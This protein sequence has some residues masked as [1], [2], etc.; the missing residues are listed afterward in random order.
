MRL[1]LLQVLG[2]MAQQAMAVCEVLVIEFH[3]DCPIHCA[4]QAI[5]CM[6]KSHGHPSYMLICPCTMN[7]AKQWSWIPAFTAACP[8]HCAN[9]FC[10]RPIGPLCRPKTGLEAE[11]KECL[12]SMVFVFCASQSQDQKMSEIHSS[13]LFVSR[14][15][16]AFVLNVSVLADSSWRAQQPSMPVIPKWLC[17]IADFWILWKSWPKNP[18]QSYPSTN[19]C[20]SCQSRTRTVHQKAGDLIH[21]RGIPSSHWGKWDDMGCMSLDEGVIMCY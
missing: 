16:R 21:Q 8:I 13:V 18:R 20:G 12:P 11:T 19:L 9:W 14:D 4:W 6:M 5:F 17:L 1:T 3:A 10:I 7:M 2:P 15:L